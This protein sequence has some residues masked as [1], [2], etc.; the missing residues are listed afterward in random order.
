MRRRLS[1]QGGFTLI[2]TIV[3]LVIMAMIG[4]LVM[5]RKPWQS[6]GWNADAT[7]RALT[8]GLQLARSRAIAQDRVV[9]VITRPRGF[10]IDGGAAWALPAD[11]ALSSSEVVFAPDG[12]STGGTILLGAGNRRIALEVNW[13]TGRVRTRETDRR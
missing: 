1:R 13:L 4:G 2:E 8:N 9:A 3:V 6:S 7:V 10:S 5:V 11:E 12:G